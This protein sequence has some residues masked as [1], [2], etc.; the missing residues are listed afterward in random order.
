[1]S[2]INLPS[3]TARFFP[4]QNLPISS[5]NQSNPP[6]AQYN[7]AQAAMNNVV[8]T[9]SSKYGH[10]PA[11]SGA[12]RRSSNAP[13]RHILTRTTKPSRAYM[14]AQTI[15]YAVRPDKPLRTL[16]GSQLVRH[17]FYPSNQPLTQK[18]STSSY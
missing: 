6:L 15:T 1:L 13:H 7:L 11:S 8:N 2:P 14:I 9:S 4:F 12:H 16:Q 18:N 5:F 10:P 3:Q 17:A